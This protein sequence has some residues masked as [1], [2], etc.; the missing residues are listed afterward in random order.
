M[1]WRKV[2]NKDLYRKAG[3]KITIKEGKEISFKS[4]VGLIE[5]GICRLAT[6]TPEGNERVYIYFKKGNL[7]GFLRHLLPES[8]YP[9]SH[10]YKTRNRVRSMTEVTMYLIEID[11]YQ[12]LLDH[13]SEAYIDLTLALAQNLSNMLEHSSLVACENAPIRICT[14]LIEFSEYCEG[15]WFLPRCFTQNEIANFLSLHKI[16][17]A[18]IFKTLRLA[19]YIQRSKR[20]IELLDKKSLEMIIRREL[21]IRY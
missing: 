2:T 5:S 19:G 17:V 20:D 11:A 1:F 6:I 14:M 7:V 15:R 12:H 21:C 8:E 3:K 9:E 18:K 13:E 4:H 10:I 16:T